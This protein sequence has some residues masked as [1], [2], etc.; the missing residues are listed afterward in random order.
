[1]A[2]N[3][4]D[5]SSALRRAEVYSA[6][7][8]DTLKDDY[9]PEG[10]HRDVSDFQDGDTLH[11][12]TFG[13]LT[14]RDL[15]EDQPTPVDPMDS[16]EITLTITDYVGN[17]V[18]LTDKVRQDSWK[19][20]QF[21]AAIV[22][23]QLRAIKERFETDLL[24]AIP[25]GQTAAN[26]NAING[27]AH[28][29]VASG[30]N[31][32]I[33]IEDFVYMKLAFDKANAADEGRIAIF[34]PIAEATLNTLANLI[35]GSFNPSF[36]GIV[37]TGFAKNMKFIRNIMGFDVYLSNRLKR[38]S[39]E[40]IDTDSITIP[41]PSGGSGAV[42]ATNAVANLFLCVGDDTE[43]P[44]M[45]AWRQQPYFEGARNARWRRDEFF[46][47]AR[48]G[49]GLQRTQTAGVILTSRVKYK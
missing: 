9:L 32:T 20:A 33:T 24:A 29:F 5:N 19:A 27:L 31:V 43:T 41:A 3:T 28:R 48:W 18:Y 16:G 37:E 15:T 25:N 1:M 11:I 40:S 35:N 17:G 45:G 4:T 44:I 13:D 12:T 39:S 14:L 47:A 34:D 6:L 36:Q 10:I 22:P 8:L 38:I 46:A 49:F 21:D 30:T 26:A 2:G 42:A 7:I 23:K